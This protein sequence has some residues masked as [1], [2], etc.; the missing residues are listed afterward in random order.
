MASE[1]RNDAEVEAQ[2]TVKGINVESVETLNRTVAAVRGA[3]ILSFQI[4]LCLPREHVVS[5]D[6]YLFPPKKYLPG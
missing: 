6:M 4:A 5:L 1:M 3:K 2:Q